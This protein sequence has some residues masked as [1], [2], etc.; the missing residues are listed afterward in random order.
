MAPTVQILKKTGV[1]SVLARS[2]TLGPEA[3]YYST[4]LYEHVS[5][6]T[7]NVVDT[8]KFKDL[9]LTPIVCR[10]PNPSN[11]IL[12]CKASLNFN[13]YENPWPLRLLYDVTFISAAK[14]RQG[15]HFLWKDYHY[16]AVKIDDL[17]AI[18]SFNGIAADQPACIANGPVDTLFP[19]RDESMNYF[20]LVIDDLG[21]PD[22]EVFARAWCSHMDLSAVVVDIRRSCVSCGVREAYAAGAPVVITTDVGN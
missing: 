20:V 2:N 12:L 22:N 8:I 10:Q 4:E 19:G 6:D 7:R 13:F 15:P 16:R 1:N 5:L 21:E 14:C 17:P 11:G 18:R 9:A 3:D